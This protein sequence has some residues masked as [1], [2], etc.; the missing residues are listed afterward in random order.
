MRRVIFE[1]DVEE[2][3][4]FFFFMAENRHSGGEIN[5]CN[6]IQIYLRTKSSKIVVLL[7]HRLYVLET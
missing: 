2:C 7:E 4:D 1:K 5:I 6:G 3:M